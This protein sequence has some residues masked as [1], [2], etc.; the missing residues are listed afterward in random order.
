VTPPVPAGKP[1]VRL[2][3]P[4]AQPKMVSPAK[5]SAAAPGLT[6][7]E[8]SLIAEIRR[9]QVA[10]QARSVTSRA[11]AAA[12]AWQHA[13]MGQAPSVRLVDEPT[14][15]EIRAELP[16]AA[17]LNRTLTLAVRAA[18]L[19]YALQHFGQP[20][21][22][23]RRAITR[24]EAASKLIAYKRAAVLVPE[25][26]SINDG[27]RAKIAF[28]A[29]VPVGAVAAITAIGSRVP[30]LDVPAG[31]RQ[32]SPPTPA[33]E[34]PPAGARQVSPPTTPAAPV[35]ETGLPAAPL[36]PGAEQPPPGARQVSPPPP[37]PPR[38]TGAAPEAETNWPVIALA[39]LVGRE[40]RKA[41]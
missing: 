12:E 27:I 28:D 18:Q 40:S 34:A 20:A 22:S 39:Y 9:R 35:S 31:A 14:E 5:P 41:A 13:G 10:T 1:V 29:G 24:Q 21:E 6:T 8:A 36:A 4:S 3:A 38:P 2:P 26:S 19:N 25:D 30:R 11:S 32:V 16:N 7:E 37:A 33:A 15:A 17:Q 23:G